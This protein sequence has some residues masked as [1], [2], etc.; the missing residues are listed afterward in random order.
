MSSRRRVGT[1]GVYAIGLGCMNL[2]HAYGSP[3]NEVSAATLRRAH[4]I[5]PIAAVQS[6]YS[7]WSR[8]VEVAILEETRQIGAAFVAFSPLARGFLTD[9]PPVPELFSPSDIR[10][11]M[12]RFQE[13]NWSSNL[14]VRAR[15]PALAAAA[16]VSCAQLCLGWLLSRGPHIIPIPGTSNIN[17]L[18]D[19][20]G[21][22][23]V[24]VSNESL[25][26]LEQLINSSTI[27]GARY[28]SGIQSKI[29][30][31]EMPH[32]PVTSSPR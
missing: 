31:E 12:P 15:L 19:N 4:A 28:S 1:A 7:L 17:H 14:A 25:T 6:E 22:G 11:N 5:H 32:R 30:T 24:I 8:N 21:A 2:S 29:D 13:P 27:R 16:G 20:V 10:R 23:S 3:P 26:Q 18:N 9:Q